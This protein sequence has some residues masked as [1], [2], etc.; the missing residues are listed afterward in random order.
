LMWTRRRGGRGAGSTRVDRRRGGTS[1]DVERRG[2]VD[3]D[4]L[5]F[6]VFVEP[7]H[8]ELAADAAALDATER[9]LRQPHVMGVDPDVADAQ[10]TR[11]ADR[12]V[13][14]ARPDRTAE[15]ERVVVRDRQRLVLIVERQHGQDRP[16]DLLPRDR[17]LGTHVIEDRR[18]HVEAVGPFA[19]ESLA[20]EDEPRLLAPTA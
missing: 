19:T 13:E 20:A 18:R 3:A 1:A 15:P 10:P 12:P 11:Q 4:A 7:F 6:E 8:A 17:H 16:E 14:V 9:A 5:R 2:A